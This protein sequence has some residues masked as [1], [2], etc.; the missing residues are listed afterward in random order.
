MPGIAP[1]MIMGTVRLPL[2]ISPCS[3]V[4][5]TPSR[6]ASTVENRNCAMTARVV[7]D[8]AVGL[9]I[10][11]LSVVMTPMVPDYKSSV[12]A[13]PVVMAFYNDKFLDNEDNVVILMKLHA[14]VIA[15]GADP[16]VLL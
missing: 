3:R 13:G 6:L 4:L 5:A 15:S 14:Q 8:M 11:I 12:E 10:M 1:H 2:P 7:S 9:M 16:L